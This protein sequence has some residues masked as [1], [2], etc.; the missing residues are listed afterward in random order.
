MPVSSTSGFVGSRG[1]HWSS[2]KFTGIP[3]HAPLPWSRTPVAR[4]SLAIDR[5]SRTGPRWVNGEDS[6]QGETFEAQ[7]HG[8]GARCQRFA[9]ASRLTAHDSLPAVWLKARPD[10]VLTRWA[11]A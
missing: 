4:L 2:P 1:S 11:A 9:P 10:G 6:P 5:D 3:C 7:S 8:F